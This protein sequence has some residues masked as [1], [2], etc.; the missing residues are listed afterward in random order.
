MRKKERFLFYG[1]VNNMLVDLKPKH[2]PHI[3]GTPENGKV[4]Y[5]WAGE[6]SYPNNIGFDKHFQMYNDIVD[7]LH[8]NVENTKHNA[9]WN[10]IG[11][12]IYVQLRKRE[13]LMMFVLRWGA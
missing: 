12:C 4:P 3:P 7:W 1:G 11:D 5:G 9:H 6:R 8:T 10:K 2:W 13:N